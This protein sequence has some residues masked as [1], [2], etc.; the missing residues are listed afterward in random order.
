MKKN[1]I[2][3][4]TKKRKEAQQRDKWNMSSGIFCQSQDNS[5]S[6]WTKLAEKSQAEQWNKSKRG[7]ETWVVNL[8]SRVKKDAQ[9]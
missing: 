7:Q 8:A 2:F 5:R 6:N 1:K 3:I 9:V 4:R